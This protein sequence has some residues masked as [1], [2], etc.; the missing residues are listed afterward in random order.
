VSRRSGILLLVIVALVA[1]GIWVFGGF[2][3]PRPQFQR[4]GAPWTADSGGTIRTS[5]SR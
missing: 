3:W 5:R 4:P 2:L 1:V